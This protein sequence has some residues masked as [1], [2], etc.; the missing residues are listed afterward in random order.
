LLNG[1]IYGL[2][3]FMVSAGLTLI[4]GM[5][6]VL[7][8]SHASFYMV[9]AYLA[10]SLAKPLGFW[11]AIIIAPLPVGLL[12]VLVE[13]Y[14]LR[15][16]HRHGHA[17]ELLVTFGLSLIIAE[18]IKLFY[19]N[20]PVDYH[21]PKALNF[22][23]FHVFMGTISLVMFGLVFLLLTR[24]RVGIIVRSAIYRPRMAEALGHN[25]PL[26]FMGVFGIGAMLA[27]LAGAVAGAFYSTSP[28]MAL[29]FGVI[30]FVVVVVGGLGSLEG[31][32]VASLLIG[33]VTTFAVG[34]DRSLAD[35]FA[36]FGARQWAEHVGGLMTLNISSLAAT[37][38]FVLMLLVLM[39]RPSGLMGEKG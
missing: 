23:A 34:V 26:V 20:Y 2:L 21:V 28:T 7:N 9:G 29:D 35:V 22:A 1:A 32:M 4:F 18:V 24:T 8:F 17:H 37:I 12:G 38:P 15:R 39:L 14:F 11:L 5:M 25:V 19:G 16:V 27:G 30:V 10:F 31:A 36:L 3:L 13:R 6:G 33:L